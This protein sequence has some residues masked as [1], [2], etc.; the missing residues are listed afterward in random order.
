M[1]KSEECLQDLWEYIK[2]TNM[3]IIRIPE[4]EEEGQ[5]SRTCI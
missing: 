1:K 5:G 3:R 2:R 4:E